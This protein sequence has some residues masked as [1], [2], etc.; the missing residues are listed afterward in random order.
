MRYARKTDTSQQAIVAALRACGWLVFCVGEPCDLF[1][2]KNGVWRALEVKTPR[3]KRGDPRL[4]KRQAE[5]AEF[6]RL[7]D[8][9][10]VTT[11]EGA[12]QALG[13]SFTYFGER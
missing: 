4:D 11:P 8:T 5:Q 7:T 1:A 12:L 9:P 3:N 13:E 2:Y 10:Y 6:C